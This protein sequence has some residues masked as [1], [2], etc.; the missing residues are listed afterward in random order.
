LTLDELRVGTTWASVT[1]LAAAE[2]DADFDDDEDV[3]G[4]DLLIWQRGQGVGMT[5]AE[6]DANDDDVVDGDD[7]A[8]WEADFGT[9]TANAAAV[10][11]PAS[12]ALAALAAVGAMYFRPNRAP[13]NRR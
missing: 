6:G 9:A 5:N 12:L 11:E 2:D 10:P 4:N 1:S 7:L 13:R 3:D 8:I